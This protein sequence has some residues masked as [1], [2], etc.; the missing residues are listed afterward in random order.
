M[1]RCGYTLPELNRLLDP[2]VLLRS[3]IFV[4]RMTYKLKDMC[5][6]D[7]LIPGTDQHCR[8]IEAEQ[9]TYM[10]KGH[11]IASLVILFMRQLSCPRRQILLC[12]PFRCSFC[13]QN[14][15]ARC[16]YEK[17]VMMRRKEEATML[18]KLS[19]KNAFN[20]RISRGKNRSTDNEHMIS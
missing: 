16:D 11:P 19:T 12:Y 13:N 1:E 10:S 9:P 6:S 5:C 3:V 7:A 17:Q 20:R 15:K 4:T 2:I 8:A 14:L 18:S